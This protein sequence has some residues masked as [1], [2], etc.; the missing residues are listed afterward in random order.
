MPKK[1][2]FSRLFRE[3]VFPR[4]VEKYMSCETPYLR[5][6]LGMINGAMVTNRD[7]RTKPVVIYQHTYSTGGDNLVV[8][9]V[10]GSLNS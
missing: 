2:S 9:A 5:G 6:T 1:A 3:D 4:Q 8:K 10:S 7:A